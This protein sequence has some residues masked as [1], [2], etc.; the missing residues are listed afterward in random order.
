MRFGLAPPNYA[1]WFD[2][3]AIGEIS[4]HAEDLGFDSLWFG[5]HVALPQAEADIFGNAYLDV[6]ALIGYVAAITTKLR[7]GTNVLVVPYRN[8]IVTAKMVASLDVLSG[9][10]IDLGVGI[11]HVAGE[12][13]ALGVP[14]EERGRISDE[15]LRAMRVLWDEDCA[16]FDGHWVSFRDLCPLTRPT[17]QPFPFLVGGD[18]SRSMRRAIEHGAG[19]APG[20]GTVEELETKVTKLRELADTAGQPCPRIVARWLVHPVEA[21]AERPPI[22]HRGELRRPRLDPSEAREQIDRIEALGIDEVIVD[23][24]A[25]RNTYSSNMDLV[26]GS[27][28]HR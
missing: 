27:L 17:Q 4:Q 16:S 20:Q 25:H 26:A 28:I 14:F 8:P 9:G 12:F 6:V 10:R 13:A 2:T 7:L 21:G 3:A 15:Y 23:I 22:P 1:R 18:G 11:G 19:W 5:D 24:P